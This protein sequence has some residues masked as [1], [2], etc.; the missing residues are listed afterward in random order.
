MKVAISLFKD[1]VSPHFSTAPEALLVQIEGGRICATWKIDLARLS[2]TVRRAKLLGLGIETLFCGG[3]D[4]TSRSWFERQGVGVED[5][6]M[7][8]AM[9]M[10]IAHLNVTAYEPSGG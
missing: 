9:E 1:R 5:N 2:P 8:N 10:L 4:E 7:G 3:I 6:R